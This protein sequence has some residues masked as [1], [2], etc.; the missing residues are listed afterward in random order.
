MPSKCL[1]SLML[2]LASFD[3]DLSL[4]L[5]LTLTND[6]TNF[7]GECWTSQR[8]GAD[9]GQHKN[10]PIKSQ[11]FFVLLN[12]SGSISGVRQLHAGVEECRIPQ[13]VSWKHDIRRQSPKLQEDFFNH[14]GVDHFKTVLPSTDKHRRIS[15]ILWNE[16]EDNIWPQRP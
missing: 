16:Y 13:L 5:S 9:S 10:T 3:L 14:S 15:H 12:A 6:E 2:S 7:P 11:R 8:V 4:S 1:L